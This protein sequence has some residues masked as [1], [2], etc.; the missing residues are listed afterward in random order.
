MIYV[1]FLDIIAMRWMLQVHIFDKTPPYLQAQ[2]TVVVCRLT[3]D[4][5]ISHE[6]VVV[7]ASGLVETLQ[8][9]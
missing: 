1:S 6:K 3:F 5:F 2:A 7:E 9:V 4:G 8:L